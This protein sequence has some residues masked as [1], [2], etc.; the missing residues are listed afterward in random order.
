MNFYGWV[1]D[2][3]RRAVLLGVSDAVEQLGAPSND[4]EMSKHLLAVLRE[5]KPSAEMLGSNGGS[6]KA[7]EHHDDIDVDL[8]E[9]SSSGGTATA[10]KSKSRRKTKATEEQPLGRRRLGRTL[11]QLSTE[12]QQAEAANE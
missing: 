1:R 6:T 2:G 3:V 11:S 9:G 7:L 12:E 5:H 4:Q 10:T 8:E